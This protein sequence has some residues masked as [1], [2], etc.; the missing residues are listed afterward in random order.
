MAALGRISGTL[1]HS[2]QQPIV[3]RSQIES[4]DRLKR[5]R[6]AVQFEA[7]AERAAGRR[8]ADVQ[9]Q[10]SGGDATLI[11]DA[12]IRADR[13]ERVEDVR[14]RCFIRNPGDQDQVLTAFAIAVAS[15]RPPRWKSAIAVAWTN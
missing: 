15:G 13:V 3:H 5:N 7:A 1:R 11:E 10:V 14:D 12:K 2:G 9:A 6:L 4:R 8:V